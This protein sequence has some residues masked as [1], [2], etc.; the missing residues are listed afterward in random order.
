VIYL[1]CCLGDLL[2]RER[3]VATEPLQ[4]AGGIKYKLLLVIYLIC[5]LGDLL[6]REG[7]MAT[8]PL[9]QAG[10][11]NDG[12]LLV[13]LALFALCDCDIIR[14]CNDNMKWAT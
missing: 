14:F 1:I 2:P 12:L 7:G 3:R 11:V 6:P 10:D 8:E 13:L 9:Q 5:C 4:H